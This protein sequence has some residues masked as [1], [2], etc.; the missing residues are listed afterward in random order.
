MHNWELRP[1]YSSDT[2]AQTKASLATDGI[3]M[4]LTRRKY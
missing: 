1:R 4:A 3:L 2:M